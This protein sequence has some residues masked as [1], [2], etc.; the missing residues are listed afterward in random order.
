MNRPEDGRLDG[1]NLR[2][3]FARLGASAAFWAALLAALAAGGHGLFHR[4]RPSVPQTASRSDPVVRKP[5]SVGKKPAAR[6]DEPALS[7]PEL[8]REKFPT[9]AAR[10]GSALS[11]FSAAKERAPDGRLVAGYRPR[12]EEP[13]VALTPERK[14]YVALAQREFG[15]S[16]PRFFYSETDGGLQLSRDGA[17]IAMTPLYG[18]GRAR[19]QVDDGFL[20]YPEVAPGLDV[21]FA[22]TPGASEKLYLVRRPLAANALRYRLLAGGDAGDVRLDGAALAVVSART[23]ERV[24]TLTPPQIF[25]SAGRQASGRY[26]L[27][28]A[29]GG[30][31]WTLTLS[32]DDRGLSYPLLIDPTWF[33]IQ[34]MN[35]ARVQATLTVLPSG[36]VLVAGGYSGAAALNTAELYDPNAGTWTLI[37][38]MNSARYAHT[39]TLLLNGQVLVVGGN[40][41]TPA[42][43]NAIANAELYNP[44]TGNWTPTTALTAAAMQHTATLLP[45]GNVLVVGGN[46][47]AAALAT[48]YVYNPNTTLWTA[49]GNNLPVGVYNHAAT[50]IATNQVLISGGQNTAGTSQTQSEIYDPV[51]NTFAATTGAMNAAR[52]NHVLVR[53]STGTVL[54][55]GGFAGGL[56]VATAENFNA[57]TGKWTVTGNMVHAR[58][59][60]SA[61]LLPS[62]Q[63]AVAGGYGGG[64]ALLTAELYTPS[65]GTWGATATSL[66]IARESAAGALLP[67]AKFMVAGGSAAAVNSSVDILDL[68]GG[69]YVATGNM[70]VTRSAPTAT[71]LPNGQVL[72][73]GGGTN[74]AELYNPATGA[75]TATAGNMSVVRIGHTASMLPTGQV[76]ITGGGPSF[77]AGASYAS[78]E[79]YNP[80]TQTFALTG[81]MNT[82]RTVHTSTLLNS[83]K[84]LV[85]G[86]STN[87][88]GSVVTPT[89]ELYDPNTAVWTPTS[90]LNT[91]R[92]NHSAAILIN[93]NALIVGGQAAFGGAGLNTAELYVSTA[94]TFQY[95]T[96]NLSIAR[97]N[98]ESLLLGNGSV[99][100]IGGSQ[101]GA[102]NNATATVDIYNPATGLWSATGAMPVALQQPTGTLLPNGKVY[103]A[104][105]ISGTGAYLNSTA[106]YDVAAGTWT[107]GP[108]MTV[109]RV[110][111]TATLLQNGQI[112]QAGGFNGGGNLLSAE[113]A[114]YTEYKFQGFTPS[115]QPAI[116]TVNGIVPPASITLLPGNSYAITGSSLA[117]VSDAAGGTQASGNNLPHIVFRGNDTGTTPPQEQSA[118][119]VDLSTSV[120]LH[121]LS[122]TT[123]TVDI[124]TNIGYGH[125]QMYVIANG[126]ISTG[127]AVGIFPGLPTLAPTAAPTTFFPPP[128]STSLVVNW[129]P[130]GEVGVSG[131][132]IEASTAANFT[133]NDFFGNTAIPTSTGI[134]NG[135]LSNTTYYV[136]VAAENITG[137]G[138]YSASLGSTSTL[139]VPLA[140]FSF[141]NV[142][143]TSITASWTALPAAPQSATAEFYLLQATSTVNLLP[144]LSSSQTANMASNKLTDSG[145]WANTTYYVV[146]N[147]VNWDGLDDPVL[148]GSTMTLPVPPQ[149]VV[150]PFPLVGSSSVTVSWSSGT[151]VLGYDGPF[152][153]YAIQASTAAN[154]SGTV[155]TA[156]SSGLSGSVPGLFPNTTYFFQVGVTIGVST[157]SYALMGS[158]ATLT[159]LPNPS[160]SSVTT[161]S[162]GVTWG[163]FALAPSSMTD[164]GF[165]LD[166]S[167]APN[168]TGTVISSVSFAPSIS[169]L[170]VGGLT[171]LTTYYMRLGSVNWES[172]T[173]YIL[174]GPVETADVIPAIANLFASSGTYADSISYQ[175]TA[176][177]VLGG[178]GTLNNGFYIIMFTTDTVFAQGS[179]WTSTGTI[180]SDVFRVAIATTGV[181]PGTVQSSTTFSLIE[182][183]TYY[184]RVYTEDSSGFYSPLSNGATAYATPKWYQLAVVPAFV[185]V[186][187]A[188]A[189][190]TTVLSTVTVT[191]LGNIG[192]TVQLSLT[193]PAVWTATAGVPIGDSFRL[194][195]I[196]TN[197]EPAAATFNTV[198]DLITTSTV[199]ASTTIY[200]ISTDPV[201]VQGVNIQPGQTR[202][203]YLRIELPAYSSTVNPQQIYLQGN[204]GP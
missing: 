30:R 41:G 136:R 117:G 132:L 61:A 170:T 6:P 100:A 103:I 51:A 79:L 187:F 98:L 105:G 176:Q 140:G 9:V 66:M 181:V 102:L 188:L 160:V 32:Y 166:A 68:G 18:A 115:Q 90:P 118:E 106:L 144:P 86:G 157:K 108:N 28:R 45:S 113:I 121:P 159:R 64:A 47:G 109:A 163:K 134:V 95:T 203:L 178:A 54:A 172:A 14:A 73:A 156:T 56:A 124:P 12:E 182:G 127:V 126:V 143:S 7:A 122:S 40:S 69:A 17:V 168:F 128:N 8:V 3:V 97:G 4:A 31:A 82:G 133:G 138:P 2:E 26:A 112:L 116:A 165:E 135:V 13:G 184:Y 5:E 196:F 142:T 50:V 114:F 119:F 193:N 38:T 174:I 150:P 46:S 199:T 72:I 94:G 25:D 154:F 57:A 85:T 59:Q 21:L 87:S 179:G 37:N 48:G 42:A 15:R 99:I 67:S 191:N 74:T 183:D 53:Y 20:V 55:A 29:D 169:T 195:G 77:A 76:L 96:N 43:P 189:S 151:A 60:A 147:S 145:L 81:P 175:W 11:D 204:P 19:A 180:P 162:I 192:T 65:V 171:M 164:E 197:P 120:Y 177:G 34:G 125:Y 92:I 101:T 58:G 155:T 35:N 201:G 70:T 110:N 104:G 148:V 71:L 141:T 39:A 107:V 161:N 131:Y 49:V 158:T 137:L 123:M 33:G 44:V 167:T 10:F 152:T 149:P 78:C 23:G 129:V 24:L 62:G 173:N 185:S 80:A 194:T 88:N 139:A 36:Q 16:L 190:T 27:E 111:Q 1:A 146:L 83:G 22:Q 63:I 198:T 52:A 89:A 75:F 93:G 153:L 84:V 186:D 91:A 202:N 200:A 130:T